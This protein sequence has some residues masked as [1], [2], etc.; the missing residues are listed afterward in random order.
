MEGTVDLSLALWW[1]VFV[2][3]FRDSPS[4][5]TGGHSTRGSQKRTRR[6]I[7]L[8]LSS[9]VGFS[10]AKGHYIL[11]NRITSIIHL[12]VQSFTKVNLISLHFCLRWL[13][14]SV[15]EIRWRTQSWQWPWWR[16]RGRIIR[17]GGRGFIYVHQC[18]PHRC[19]IY[20]YFRLIE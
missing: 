13:Q 19:T 6:R 16:G 9:H 3:Q 10:S 5:K 8:L 2:L 4:I 17:W 14:P 11:H 20:I 1:T 15:A 7:A 12:S 18:L